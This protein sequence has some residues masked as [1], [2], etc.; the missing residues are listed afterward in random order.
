MEVPVSN[1]EYKWDRSRP[2]G[3]VPEGSQGSFAETVVYGIRYDD[4]E[5]T[6]QLPLSGIF[7]IGPTFVGGNFHDYR[8]VTHDGNTWLVSPEYLFT[9]RTP[10][11][12]THT[13]FKSRGSHHPF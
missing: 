3:E 11:I 2:L 10:Y 5:V 1:I 6:E 8:F 12:N 13:A 4:W 7:D 9:K